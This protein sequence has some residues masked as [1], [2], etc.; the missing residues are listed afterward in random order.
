MRN[1][2][3]ALEYLITYGWV[4]MLVLLAL[5]VGFYFGLLTPGHFI[6]EQCIISPQIVCLEAQIGTDGWVLMKLQ[7]S[8]GDTINIGNVTSLDILL[9]EH[10]DN[11]NLSIRN[12]RQGILR[13]K[14]QDGFGPED[15][16]SFNFRLEFQRNISGA[17]IHNTSAY[18]Y[19]RVCDGVLSDDKMHIRNC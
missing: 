1:A 9:E 15:R 16:I 6:T 7:N 8:M 13:F 3:A 12:G 11:N 17:P 19:K 2:Q 14:V 10:D 18:V 4:A 5:G